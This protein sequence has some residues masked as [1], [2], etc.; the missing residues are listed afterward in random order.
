MAADSII[1]ATLDGA[2]VAAEGITRERVLLPLNF[3]DGS[4]KGELTA[5]A[6]ISAERTK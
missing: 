4:S 2:I 1:T 3:S 5:A 6:R